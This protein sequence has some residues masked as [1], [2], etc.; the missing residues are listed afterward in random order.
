MD[1]A[2]MKDF[3]TETLAVI[4]ASLELCAAVMWTPVLPDRKE[5]GMDANTLSLFETL[6]AEKAMDV[7]L[8]GYGISRSLDYLYKRTHDCRL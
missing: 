4:D 1:P 6:G 8:G 2:L 3:S 5:G 7:L